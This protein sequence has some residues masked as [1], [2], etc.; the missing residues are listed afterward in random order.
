[1]WDSTTCYGNSFIFTVK[2]LTQEFFS[3]FE[4]DRNFYKDYLREEQFRQRK[5]TICH[6]MN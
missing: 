2:K 1:M 6:G 3:T 4:G 5:I